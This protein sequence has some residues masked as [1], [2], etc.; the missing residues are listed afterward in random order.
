MRC[1]AIIDLEA[2]RANY[3]HLEELTG[4]SAAILCVVKADAYGHGSLA[5]ARAL[6]DAG[7]RHFAVATMEE[8]MVLRDGG[9]GA[10]ILVLGGLEPGTEQD[11]A[12]RGIDPL[13]GTVDELRNWD[14]TA[15]AIGRKLSCHLL[16]NT[17]MNRLGIDFDPGRGVGREEVLGALRDCDWVE[18]RGVA[19]HYASA[20]DFRTR[21]TEGQDRL[22]AMQVESL[23]AAGFAPRY[24]HAANSAA[25]LYRG[26]AGAGG[27]VGHTMVRPGLALY[28][29]VKAPAGLSRTAPHRLRPALEWRA[30]LR[31]IRH[32]PAGVPIGYGASFVAPRAMKIGILVVGYGDGLDWRLSNRG[33]VAIHGA[34]CPIV[35]EISMDLTIVDLGPAREAREGDEAVLLGAGAGDAQ[36]MAAQTG[37]TPYEVLC[38]I[39]KRVPREYREGPTG[40]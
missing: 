12:L 33:S 6:G 26:I 5:V 4:R 18:P 3:K 35:G 19:T 7:A 39:S 2:L 8:A 15:R 27:R 17:G 24:I 36:N 34:Q 21:Q 30:V 14:R 11:A 25:I 29:Y 9:I 32:V 31:R 16:F 37:G 10:P 28:G 1:R 38:G 20:E 22:F 13:I 23:R 40:R